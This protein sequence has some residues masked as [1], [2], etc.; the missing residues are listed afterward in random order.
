MEGIRSFLAFVRGL[1][2]GGWR[3]VIPSG[4]KNPKQVPRFAQDDYDTKAV[5]YMASMLA[6][7]MSSMISW[8][9]VR[10]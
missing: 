5:W 8:L 6:V 4:A 7:G 10:T 2:V 1:G 3:P 9:P